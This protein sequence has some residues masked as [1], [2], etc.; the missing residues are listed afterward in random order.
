M[1]TLDPFSGKTVTM[2]YTPV[3]TGQWGFVVVVPDAE[4]LADANRLRL[5]L[6]IVCA[7]GILLMSGLIS[8]VTKRLTRPIVI[9]SK[10]ADQIASGDLQLSLQAGDEDEIG[11]TISAFNNMVKYLQN[12]AGVAQKVADGDLTENVQP[13]SAR[14]V[15]GN[16]IS[17]MVTNLHASMGDVNVTARALLESSGQLDSTSS[18]SGL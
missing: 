18:Q 16:A 3:K 2:F 6:I 15:L 10:A 8:F 14:D 4:M 11:Q 13:Q 5:I 9:I 12:M 17:N 7:S 1:N